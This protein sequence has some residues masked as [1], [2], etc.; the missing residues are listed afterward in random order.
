MT[1]QRAIERFREQS[2]MSKR[3]GFS[4]RVIDLDIAEQILR[5]EAEREVDLDK[6]AKSLMLCTGSPCGEVEPIGMYY[7]KMLTSVVLTAAGVK[8]KEQKMAGIDKIYGT[9]D[10][11]CD[12]HNW[13]ARSKRPQYCR[14]F[15]PTPNYGVDGTHIGCITNT[16]VRVDRWLW[17]NCPLKF[18]KKRLKEMY[19]GRRP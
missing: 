9:Y 4:Q 5:E 18:V 8:Y 6:C 7:A 14:Y 19:N 16:P 1:T 17:D 10:Q 11:W 15:Y 13:M 2:Y 3:K 12:F